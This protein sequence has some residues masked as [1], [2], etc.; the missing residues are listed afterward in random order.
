MQASIES[1]VRAWRQERLRLLPGLNPIHI[2]ELL[3]A[4]GYSVSADVVKLYSLTAGMP[5][6]DDMDRHLFWL[7]PFDEAIIESRNHTKPYMVFA[8]G[9]ISAYLYCWKYESP[10]RSSVHVWGHTEDA[11][12]YQQIAP[13]LEEAF[14]LLQSNPAKFL[15]P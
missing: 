15:L 12:V 5:S 14:S 2:R 11:S 4:A 10:E 8:D 6:I 13:S 7:M 1:A 9:F 3:G